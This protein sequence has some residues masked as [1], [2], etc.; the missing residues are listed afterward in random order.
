LR[1]NNLRNENSFF[2]FKKTLATLVVSFLILAYYFYDQNWS[3]I[4]KAA[5][6]ANISLALGSFFFLVI[7]QWLIEVYF[8]GMHF[9]W[10]HGP[11]PWKDYFWMR[12]AL[13]LVLLINGPLSGGARMLYLVKKTGITWTLYF[14]LAVFRLILLSGVVASIMLLAT[15]SMLK[16]GLFEQSGIPEGYWFAF[17][18]W[19][20]FVFVDFYLAFFHKKYFGISRLFMNK[21][22]HEF[23]KAF[24][25]ATH[26]QWLWT[27]I[28]GAL[29]FVLLILCYWLM[30][31]AF[32]IHIP[33]WYFAISLFFVLL[34][35]NLPLSFG[36]FGTTTMAWMLFYG[37][38][39]EESL[40]LSFTLFLPL[41]RILVC[42]V[43]G[44]LCLKPALNDFF[45]LLADAQQGNS[46][47]DLAKREIKSIFFK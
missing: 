3:D 11:F 46:Q 22:N 21:V 16:E 9:T 26:L 2:S 32:G 1:E 45:E 30:A 13:H 5:E 23:F 14:G 25:N 4:L 47:K 38:Y 18:I 28:V 6:H 35:T 44:L 39:A 41:A 10:F 29:P 8:R 42:G 27:L 19:N 43:V 12:G 15:F 37:D 31:Y 20:M 40:I 7:G 24:R 36:G 33:L 17:I 34:L